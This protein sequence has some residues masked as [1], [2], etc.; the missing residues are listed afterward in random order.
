MEE[1]RQNGQK[2]WIK[3]GNSI[4][5]RFIETGLNDGVNAIVKNGL[6]VGDTV[7]LSAQVGEKVKKAKGGMSNNPL[8]PTPPR[9][10]R[11]R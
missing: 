4:R 3:N 5:P 1:M 6:A 2:V 8:T 10:K 11:M 7:V 9:G